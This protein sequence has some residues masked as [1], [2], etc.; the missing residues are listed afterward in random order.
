MEKILFLE[1]KFR[2]KIWGGKRLREI[3]S[4]DIPSDKTGEYWAISDMGDMSSV[5]T[6]G[7]F[8]RKSLEEVYQKHKDLFGNPKEATFPLLVKI[9]D[10]N[11]D[12]SIQVHPDDV[13]A[14]ELE[15]SRG[16]TECWYILNEEPASIIYGLKVDDKNEAIKLIDER[17]WDELLREVPARKGDFFF[18]EA[19]TVHAIKK[20]SLI[21]EIQQASDITYRLYDYDRKDDNGKLRDLH[22]EE[23]K[24]A[25]KINENKEEI[26]EFEREGLNGRILTRNKYFEVYEYKISGRSEFE[27]ERPYLLYSVV[28]GSGEIIIGDK[29]YEIEKGDFFILTNDVKKFYFK[30][31]LSLVEASTV[32]K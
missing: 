1:G 4:Y 30:G 9:I 15:N 5:I 17:K 18:V 29:S 2:E 32:S 20:G 27:K 26:E 10:A 7:E 16:K 31:D 28:D 23:S 6:N 14:K 11:T 12:L 21:L 19:G 3:Y 22:L 8:K 13:M 25:I 24:K